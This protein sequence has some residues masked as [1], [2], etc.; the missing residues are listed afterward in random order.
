MAQR[1]ALQEQQTNNADEYAG[2]KDYFDHTRI[3]AVKFRGKRNRRPLFMSISD[4]LCEYMVPRKLPEAH[5]R[6]EVGVSGRIWLSGWC[7]DS[8]FKQFGQSCVHRN[9]NHDQGR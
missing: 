9:F 8:V 2:Y 4:N 6:G 7:S 5:I 1:D 3:R